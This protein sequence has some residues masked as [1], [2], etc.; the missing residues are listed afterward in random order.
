MASDFDDLDPDVFCIQHGKPL[1]DG[2][3]GFRASNCEECSPDYDYDAA[4]AIA[5]RR[6]P[7]HPDNVEMR[8]LKRG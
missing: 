1:L 2:D 5:A 6:D 7:T 8:R 4:S 3:Y